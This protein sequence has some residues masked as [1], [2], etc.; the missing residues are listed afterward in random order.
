MKALKTI[1]LLSALFFFPLSVFS[2]AQKPDKIIYQGKVYSLHTNPLEFFLRF[3]RKKDLKTVQSLL[4]C[5]VA[6]WLLLRL[7]IAFFISKI[8]RLK[9]MSKRKEPGKVY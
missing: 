9:H 7:L 6:M 3:I 1:L 5:G 8:L 2:T 4:I